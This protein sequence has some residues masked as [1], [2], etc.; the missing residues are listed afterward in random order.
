M[1]PRRFTRLSAVL[2]AYV[3]AL[4]GCSSTPDVP[5]PTPSARPHSTSLRDNVAR[6]TEAAGNTQVDSIIFNAEYVKVTANGKTWEL[7]VGVDD[8]REGTAPTTLPQTSN[9]EPFDASQ[10]PDVDQ[11]E[12]IAM[13][14]RSDTNVFVRQDAGAA[15]PLFRSTVHLD[16]AFTMDLQPLERDIQTVA[17]IQ[18]MLDELLPHCGSELVRVSSERD[19]AMSCDTK[20]GSWTMDAT[21]YPHKATNNSSLDLTT[22][23]P[24]SAKQIVDA[25]NRANL[26]YSSWRFQLEMSGGVPTVLFR[27]LTGSDSLHSCVIDGECREVGG[28]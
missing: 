12:V 22:L 26:P 13:F 5:T 27:P 24:V 7:I 3:L 17:G 21:S 19:N 16:R 14:D 11:G 28:R 25:R 18:A 2:V 23:P 4:A 20:T 15:E 1:D 10:V 8:V 9:S 6:L